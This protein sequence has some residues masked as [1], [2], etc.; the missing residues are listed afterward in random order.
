MGIS[1]CVLLDNI[2]DRMFAKSFSSEY[3]LLDFLGPMTISQNINSS[4]F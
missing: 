4:K 2:W 1:V 3:Q